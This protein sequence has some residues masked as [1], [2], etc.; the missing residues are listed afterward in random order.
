LEQLQ[1]SQEIT[2]RKLQILEERQSELL[3]VAHEAGRVATWDIRNRLQNR[4][5]DPGDV[6]LSTFVV[7]GGWDLQLAIPDYRVGMVDRAI[8][9][10]QGEEP[11]AGAAVQFS[12]TSHP[13][14]L[15]DAW[16]VELASQATIRDSFP[17]KQSRVV[18]G[19]AKL[20]PSR[21][22]LK[23][24]GA[25]AR[26]TISC[27]QVAAGWLVIRDAYRAVSSRVQMLW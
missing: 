17:A 26:A 18:L 1:I 12:L 20:D 4:P 13:D 14:L 7:D 6:L 23:K 5:V 10:A 9:K 27:G 8:Q 11:T 3:I 24:D 25:I 22:P 16:L 19:R 2:R 15:L 21:L